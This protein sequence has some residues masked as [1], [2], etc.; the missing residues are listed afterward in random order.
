M[1]AERNLTPLGM[2]FRRPVMLDRIEAYCDTLRV[3]SGPLMIDIY[4]L[5]PSMP[6]PTLRRIL[7]K[8]WGAIELM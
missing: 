2:V 7:W 6:R 1:L 3:H 4:V 8:F 5:L